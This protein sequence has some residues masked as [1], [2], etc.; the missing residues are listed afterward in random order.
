MD[1]LIFCLHFMFGMACLLAGI[2]FFALWVT[3]AFI[4][5][6]KGHYVLAFAAFTCPPLGV[7]VF[8][9]QQIRYP[10]QHF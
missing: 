2:V 4:A 8:I 6:V 9:Y 5:Y 1:I 7:A 3:G 10:N